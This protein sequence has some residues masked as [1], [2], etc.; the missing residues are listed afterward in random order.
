MLA[1][2]MPI[3][4]S[5]YIHI[6]WCIRKCPYCDFNSH[7]STKSLPEKAYVQALLRDL[8]QDLVKINDRIIH[9]IFIGGGTPSLFSGASIKYLL[10]EIKSRIQ[11]SPHCEITLEA[12]P[13][14]VDQQYFAAYRAAGINRLSIGVQSFQDKHLKLLGRIH[15]GSDAIKAV[16]LA[17]DTDFANINLDL[18]YGLPQ[19]SSQD[20]IEDLQTAISLQAKHLSW[21]QLTIEPNTEFYKCPPRLPDDDQI[22]DL[23][24]QGQSLLCTAG[25]LQYEVSAYSRPGS[26]CQHNLNYWQ[27]GDYLGIGA[28]AHSKI[29]SIAQGEITRF[30][31]QRIPATY[32]NNDKA[33]IARQATLNNNDIIFEFML[34]ALRLQ[35]PL[36]TCLFN[37][38]SGLAENNISHILDAAI[39]KKMITLDKEL[40]TVTALGRRYLND[41][42]AMFLN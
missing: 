6:P 38:R 2:T 8:D 16:E 1:F 37:E 33:F 40:I 12:N 3:P 29:T 4:L 11:I 24:Q 22:S 41:L 32:L 5:L 23:E 19:Q 14:A 18:M 34:N 27:F 26:Q 35:Q 28:G 13:G 9:S 25:Y 10:S 39:D 21:Y 42:I 15:H 7:Q 31:K 36:S 17:Y 30:S 20:A